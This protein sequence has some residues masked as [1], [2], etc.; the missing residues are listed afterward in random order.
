MMSGIAPNLKS[1]VI[2]TEISAK[3]VYTL[4]LRTNS[5]I[6][7]KIAGLAVTALTSGKDLH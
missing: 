1:G 6:D 3:V 4:T 7:W 5:A 2:A